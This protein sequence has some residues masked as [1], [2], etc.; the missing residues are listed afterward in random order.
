V[1]AMQTNKKRPPR[2]ASWAIRWPSRLGTSKLAALR[3]GET[4]VLALK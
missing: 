3:F 4:A 2:A 1:S